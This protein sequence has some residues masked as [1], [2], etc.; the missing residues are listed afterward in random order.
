MNKTF[1]DIGVFVLS[2]LSL[3]FLRQELLISLAIIIA[4][5]FS[6]WNQYEKKEAIL[7]GIGILFGLLIEI[8]SDQFYQLQYWDSG[9]FFGYPLWLFLFWGYAFVLIRRVGN[10]VVK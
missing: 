1:I 4:I 2:W 9:L 8:G 10:L 6:F 5:G 7:L 3:L